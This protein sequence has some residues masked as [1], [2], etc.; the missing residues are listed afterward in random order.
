M[1]KTLPGLFFYT[2]TVRWCSYFADK[3]T[4][5]LVLRNFA[6]VIKLVSGTMGIFT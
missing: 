6:K 5:S 4:E 1:L 3:T 2:Q